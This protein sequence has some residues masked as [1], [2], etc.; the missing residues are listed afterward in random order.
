MALAKKKIEI[1]VFPHHS[2][3]NKNVRSI[4]KDA[5]PRPNKN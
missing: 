1:F 4:E 5:K 2:I 3:N